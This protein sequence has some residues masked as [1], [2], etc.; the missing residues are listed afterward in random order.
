MLTGN[1]IL[2]LPKDAGLGPLAVSKDKVVRIHRRTR[3]HQSR[4]KGQ[5]HTRVKSAG[6]PPE[7]RW[8]TGWTMEGTWRIGERGRPQLTT[9]Q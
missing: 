6:H 3:H 2:V 4:H 5:G 1:Q 9:S 8:R 7:V